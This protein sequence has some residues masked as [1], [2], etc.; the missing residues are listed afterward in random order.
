MRPPAILLRGCHLRAGTSSLDIQAEARRA[1][2][3]ADYVDARG[4]R[5]HVPP[6]ALRR[7][8]DALPKPASDLPAIVHRAGSGPIDISFERAEAARWTLRSGDRVVNA[9]NRTS[10]VVHLPDSLP[11]GA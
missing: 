4:E 7:V 8:L 5:R 11:L 2:V 9:G 10:D 3:L 1:G 6:E